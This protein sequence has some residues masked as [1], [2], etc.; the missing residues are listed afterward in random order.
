MAPALICR[1]VIAGKASGLAAGLAPA[2][3]KRLAMGKEWAKAKKAGKART[4]S[5]AAWRV[6]TAGKPYPLA[7]L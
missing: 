6:I 3:A 2:A 1:A 5:R 4:G 7:G